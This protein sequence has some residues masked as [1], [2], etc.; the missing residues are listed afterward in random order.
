MQRS[1]LGGLAAILLLC[2]GLFLWQGMS[3]TP[4]PLPHAAPPPEAGLP[5]AD[6]HARGA[7]PPAPPSAPQESR[8]ERRFARYDRNRDGIINR[9]EM[10]STRTNAFKRLDSDGNNLLSF[11]EWSAATGRRF[12]GADGNHDGRLSATE[13]AATAPQHH[14]QPRCACGTSAGR[15]A[16]RPARDA[17]DAA[18]N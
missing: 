12:D 10:L 6:P 4:P 18:D 17:E 7:P 2:G 3:Q 14:A 13:F 8:E 9:V 11:E 15:G 1:L 16:A 5:L